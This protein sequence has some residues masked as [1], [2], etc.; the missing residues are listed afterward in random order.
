MRHM[1]IEVLCTLSVF[2]VGIII[3]NGQLCY[4]AQ[5]AATA[6]A[7]LAV[8][9]TNRI[10]DEAHQAAINVNV[11][12]KETC[13]SD[14]RYLLNSEAALRPHLRS[15]SLLKGNVIWCSSFSGNER[16]VI[17]QDVQPTSKLKLYSGDQFAPDVPLLVYIMTIS[18]ETVAVGIS[19]A[20]LREA[21][22]TTTPETELVLVVG[23]SELPR[24]GKIRRT[25][26][27]SNL[28]AQ[29]QSGQ[30]PFSIRYTLPVFFSFSR[31]IH[32][33]YLLVIMNLIMA[34]IAGIFLRRYLDKY[35]TPEENLRIA[36][37]KAEIIPY[38][39]PIVDGR[40]GL[41]YGVEVLARWKHLKS[42]VIPPDLFIPVAEKSGQII[43]LTKNLMWQV[44]NELSPVANNLPDGLHIGINISAI[45]FS[46][47]AFTTDCLSFL[48]NFPDGKVKLVIELTE[49]E[50]LKL[51]QDT[52]RKID[53]LR[54]QGILLA[55][56]D[57]GTGY[58]GL[59]YLNELPVDLIKID[60]S[61]VGRISKDPDSTRLVDCVIEMA[62][63]L[64]LK[65]VAE[66]V[67]TRVQSEYLR[68][69]GIDMLQGYYYSH[70]MPGEDIVKVLLNKAITTKL[71]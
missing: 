34:I 67:E 3:I 57:F 54:K 28:T 42:G 39:Q 58:S 52:R 38:Y 71:N 36:L 17:H 40:L 26:I 11:L 60:K 9:Q 33:G 15:V 61:F 14:A 44:V 50:P 64:S 46:H 18:A 41:V 10:L 63:R 43:E 35:T 19:D 23:D 51:T 69:H 29:L 22:E 4:S 37:E 49:R 21:L 55:L 59:S 2:L 7:K 12:N 32:Q 56:D 47:P 20:H 68:D 48:N 66:G 8:T 27:K 16:R 70:P 45:H 1:L 65:I 31:L 13:S 30:Y 24:A 53:D 25:S 6:A 5:N 62:R